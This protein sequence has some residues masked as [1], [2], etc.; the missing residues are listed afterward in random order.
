M[1]IQ[2]K[3]PDGDKSENVQLFNTTDGDGRIIEIGYRSRNGKLA[4][5]IKKD[6]Y[7]YITIDERFVD[8]VE[9]RG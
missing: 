1:E 5:I 8:S 3:Y 2:V 9:K 6:G 4:S 7:L